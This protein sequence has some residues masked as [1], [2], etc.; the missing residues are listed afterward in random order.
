MRTTKRH[1]EPD[2]IKRLL[3]QPQRFSFAQA[4]SLLL[5]ALRHDGVGYQQAMREVLRFRNSIAFS[6]PASEIEAMEIEGTDAATLK[7][8]ITPA[9][10]GLLGATGTLPLHDSERLAE[11]E[12]HDHDSS[13]HALIDVF[14]NRMIGMFYE[15]W[16]KYRVEQGLRVQGDDRLLPMLLTLAGQPALLRS[17]GPARHAAAYYA[18]IL[19]TR[20]VAA[21][22]I[23]RVLREHF[24]IPMRLQQFVGCWD[25]VPT[26]RRST[27]GV[28]RPVLGAGAMLGIRVWRHDLHTRMHIGPLDETQLQQFLPGGSARGALAELLTRFAAPMI[29]WELKLSL[30]TSS[31]RSLTLTAGPA[32]RQLGWSSFLTSTP[33]VTR[34]PYVNSL[35][36]L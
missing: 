11:Q 33:G 30:A 27:L 36:R 7:I 21:S 1:Y 3:A 31:I 18:G 19:R 2:V 16:G 10:I 32:G 25:P 20:P 17:P 23:E 29:V 8:R 14:S 22:A 15:A 12:Q 6:F 24:A 26:R 4:I 5:V 35:L 9:F 28:T 34:D 13:H